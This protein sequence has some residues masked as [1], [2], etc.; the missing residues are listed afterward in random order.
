MKF[1]DYFKG[2]FFTTYN[3]IL[4]ALTLGRF[5]WLEGRV[6]KNVF[7]NWARRFQYRPKNFVEPVTEKEIIDLVKN[8]KNVRLFGSGHSFNGGVLSDV[9]KAKRTSP[10]MPMPS[11]SEIPDSF[12]CPSKPATSP[13]PSVIQ[14]NPWET[15]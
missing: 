5:V 7:R 3:I 6:R 14:A 10:A 1:I 15:T 2:A 4:N 8:S 9:V 13:S 11:R 12:T